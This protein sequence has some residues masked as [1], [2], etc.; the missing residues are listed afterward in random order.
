MKE[1]DLIPA[2]YRENIAKLRLL[3]QFIVVLIALLVTTG[4]SFAAIQHAKNGAAIKIEK[5][6]KVK[7]FTAMQ[8]E[9]LSLLE[10]EKKDLDRKWKLLTSLRSAAAPEDL[11]HAIDISLRDLAIWF[12]HLKYERK[13]HNTKEDNLVE[14]GYFIIISPTDENDSYA[15]GTTLTVSGS[16]PNHSTLSKFVKNLLDQP[17]INDARVLETSTD[18]RKESA[19]I[20]F[21]LEIVVNQNSSLS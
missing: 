11:F 6:T 13:E 5:L 4:V 8:R 12:T 19:H 21:T 15:I 10:S 16:T 3:K 9:T 20:N 7:E 18:K 2:G 17:S 1:F 14:T